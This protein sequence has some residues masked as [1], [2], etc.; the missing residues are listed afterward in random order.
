M[1]L[2]GIEWDRNSRDYSRR[3]NCDLVNRW[4]RTVAV[5]F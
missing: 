3:L 2:S 5:N 1:K 4:M